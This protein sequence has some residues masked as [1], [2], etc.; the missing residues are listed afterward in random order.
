VRL[1]KILSLLIVSFLPLFAFDSLQEVLEYLQKMPLKKRIEYELFRAVEEGRT[2]DAKLLLPLTKEVQ[3]KRPLLN[4]LVQPPQ[5]PAIVVSKKQQKLAVV[6]DNEVVERTSCI[7]GKKKGDKLKEG[8][9]RTPNGVYF[10]LTFIDGSEL[11]EIYG[12][13][14]FPLNYP[15]IIDKRLFKRDGHGIWLH[16]TNDTARR[17]YSS[18]GCVVLYPNFFEKI[19]RL[20]AFK[21]TP[22]VIVE[23]FDYT[24]PNTF[25][26]TRRSIGFFVYEWKKAWENSPQDI[27]RYLSFYSKDFISRFENLEAFKEYKRRVTKNKEWIKIDLDDLFILKD[28][29]VLDFGN[30]YVARFN[31]DYRSNNYNWSGVKLLYII[32]DDS[33]WKILAEES[34]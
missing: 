5:K 14:A 23:D 34:L 8:D 11:S 22:V 13:G 9:Q 32:K 12:K 1:Q 30:I 29:R 28:G 31:M 17:P 3:A 16:D 20:I 10:P 21:E 6:V 15:N 2:G 26:D 7:T 33:G 25:N 4:V 18:N 19:R 24:D 27:E